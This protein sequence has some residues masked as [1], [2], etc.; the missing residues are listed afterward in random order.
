[1][2]ARDI[3][4]PTPEEMGI[5]PATPETAPNEV[6]EAEVYPKIRVKGLDGVMHEGGVTLVPPKEKFGSWR[7]K[8]VDGKYETRISDSTL[9]EIRNGQGL[10]IEDLKSI[11]M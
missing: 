10:I 6:N 5:V 2:T 3:G 9:D 1:M 11:K 4:G 8:T 7:I